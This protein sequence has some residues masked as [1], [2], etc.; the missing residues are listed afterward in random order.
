MAAKYPLVVIGCNSPTLI[1][2]QNP[3]FNYYSECTGS[4]LIQLYS[5]ENIYLRIIYN[6]FRHHSQRRYHVKMQGA[7]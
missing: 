1:L 4:S 3:A 7:R 2:L 6:I 5:F